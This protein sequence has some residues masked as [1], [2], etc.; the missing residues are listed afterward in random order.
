MKKLFVVMAMVGLL[1]V[2][3]AA[4]A[5]YTYTWN[6]TNESD[7]FFAGSASFTQGGGSAYIAP[8]T[9]DGASVFARLNTQAPG[10]RVGDITG[11]GYTVNSLNNTAAVYG[12]LYLSPTGG[13][14]SDVLI[15]LSPMTWTGTGGNGVYTF[16]LN[17]NADYRTKVDGNWSVYDPARSGS[18]ADVIA[19][20]N[21]SGYNG[22]AAF[23]GP[24]IGM[25]GTSETTFTV[26][27]IGVNAVPIPAAVWLLGSG[28]LGL[29]G[30]RRKFSK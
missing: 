19:M 8:Q 23:F 6:F 15:L 12:S 14:G 1:C 27:E 13:S 22:Y 29:V 26:S 25:S 10:L 3:S 11:G 4:Q 24:Q 30:L 17:T 7:Y 28:L 2:S 20:I 9:E 16:D 5:A 21:N 18:L